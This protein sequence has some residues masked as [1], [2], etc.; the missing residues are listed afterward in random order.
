[1]NPFKE[2][3]K[4]YDAQVEEYDKKNTAELYKSAFELFAETLTIDEDWRKPAH[5]CDVEY[6]DGYFLFGTGTNSV[7]HFH[8]K[9]CKGWKF[10]IWWEYDEEKEPETLKGKVFCEYEKYV[11]KFKPSATTY[12]YDIRFEVKDGKLTE[13]AEF[14]CWDGG[15][16]SIKRV[17]MFIHKCPYVAIEKSWSACNYNVEVQTPVLSFF[18]YYC[19]IFREWKDNRIKKICDASLLRLVKEIAKRDFSDYEWEIEDRENWIPRY[20]LAVKLPDDSDKETGHYGL[21]ADDEDEEIWENKINKLKKISKFFHTYWNH[22]NV[23]D[24]LVFWKQKDFDSVNEE[25]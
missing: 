2:I 20:Q 24:G 12:S 22:Y 13:P 18:K 23:S 9:E 7:V 11:D 8:V 4:M 3:N 5:V 6:L 17:C 1:M 16:M 19:R 21:C 10:G 15:I 25:D 14:C